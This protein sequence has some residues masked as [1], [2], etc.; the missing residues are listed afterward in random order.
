ML[1][2]GS[3]APGDGF[4]PVPAVRA[5]VDLNCGL[6]PPGAVQPVRGGGAPEAGGPLRAL[7]AAPCVNSNWVR[8]L[9]HF[10]LLLVYS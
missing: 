7:T 3:A 2:V 6:C 10:K 5:V 8:V 9:N 4:D 1:H